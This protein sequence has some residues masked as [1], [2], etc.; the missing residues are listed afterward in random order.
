MRR[1]SAG[2][3]AGTGK[4]AKGGEVASNSAGLPRDVT[5]GTGL[6]DDAAR[7]SPE[8]ANEVSKGDSAIPRLRVPYKRAEREPLVVDSDQVS[9]CTRGAQVQPGRRERRD[10]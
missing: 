10:P 5:S 1:R 7:F 6:A 8:D 3:V 2:V 4:G 9:A